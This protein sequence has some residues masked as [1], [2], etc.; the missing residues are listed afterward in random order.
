LAIRGLDEDHFK[1]I[2][3]KNLTPARAVSSPEHLKGRARTLRQI[4]RAFNSPGKHIFIY[5]DRG[6]GKT[7][8][9]QTAAFIQQSSSADPILLA[10]GGVPFLSTVR[11]AVKRALPAGDAVHQ[12]KIEHKLKMG[13]LGF[14]YDMSRSLTSGVVPPIES[15]NDAVQLLR[16]VGEVHSKEP[17]IIF[18]EFDQIPDDAQRKACAEVIKQVSDQALNIRFILCGIGSSLE[19]LIGVHL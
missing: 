9:A 3:K 1:E 10:C 18:D 12:R 16:F 13:M 19:D 17:V 8:L 6:V 14:G 4:D 5:G 7:S 2:L 11:D 15:I